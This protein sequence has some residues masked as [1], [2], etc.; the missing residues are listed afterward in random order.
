MNRR[1]LIAPALALVAAASAMAQQKLAVIDMQ[2]ALVQTAD[3]KKA[4]A[5]L[6]AKY[7]PKDAEFQKR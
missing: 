5:E 3:G 7:G 2:S 6:Q 4:V 1:I